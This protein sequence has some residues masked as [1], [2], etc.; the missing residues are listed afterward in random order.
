MLASVVYWLMTLTMPNPQVSARQHSGQRVLSQVIKVEVYKPL[1][2][3][4]EYIY[5]TPGAS[6]V[7]IINNFL[8]SMKP[9]IYTS[10]QVFYV[11]LGMTLLA[12]CCQ[13][14]AILMLL[15]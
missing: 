11:L 5:L 4:P 6:F 1:Q 3:H 2:I 7:V 14:I 15:L 8:S 10:R 13:V 12:C 9:A